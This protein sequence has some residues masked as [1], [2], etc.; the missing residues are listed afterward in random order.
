MPGAQKKAQATVVTDTEPTME[1]AIE[2]LSTQLKKGHKAR[3]DALFK[4]DDFSKHIL[5]EADRVGLDPNMMHAV[6][7]GFLAHLLNPCAHC[8]PPTQPV[9]LCVLSCCA[10]S[11]SAHTRRQGT[12]SPEQEAGS[13]D[14]GHSLASHPRRQWR[15]QN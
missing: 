10:F 11:F 1:E 13:R 7:I 14:V 15:G 2:K 9:L 5:D 4:D 6:T 12:L 3:T 8:R